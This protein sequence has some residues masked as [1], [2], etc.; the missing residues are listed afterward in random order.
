MND[1]NLAVRIKSIETIACD[2]GW[3]NYNFLKLTTED[4]TVGWAEYDE[5]FGPRGLTA[6][7]AKYAPMFIGEDIFNH[8][9]TYHRVAATARPAPYGLTAEAFGAV[10]N[11]MLDAKGK[12]LGVPAYTLLGGKHRDEVPVY[13]SHCSTWRIWYPEHYGAPITDL[14]G[15]TDAGQ[16]AKERGF[17]AVKTNMFQHGPEGPRSWGAGFGNPYEPGLNID[18]KLIR[19]V[20]A[21]V[22]ALRDGVGDDVEILVDLN[23]NARTE[24]FLR[25]VRALREIDP[26]WIELDSYNPDALATIR[27]QAGVPIASCETLFGVRQFLPYLTRQAIDVGIVDV[28]WNGAWQSMKIA[29]TAE[30]FDVN[31][32]PHNFYGHLSTMMSLHFAAAVPN[33]RIME[34]DVDRLRYDDELFTYAPVLKDGHLEVPNRPGWGTEP[35]EEALRS[36]P[37]VDRIGYLQ[38]AR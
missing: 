4:G 30:A 5:A 36:H 25:L 7:I 21:H 26:F 33:L 38:T 20:V 1:N 19:D 14:A 6:V 17:S 23:F 24:G 34:H 13:W 28:I 18:R 16:E 10:E 12:I 11:A 8:E 3:R 15:V 32:A 35:N 27:E 22:E 29:N 2:A 37:P 9:R 31:V